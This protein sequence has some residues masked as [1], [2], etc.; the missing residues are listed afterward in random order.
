[1][2]GKPS[3]LF[4]TPECP[5][6]PAGGGALRTAALLEYVA[7]RYDVD[8]AAFRQPGDP[9]PRMT[10][11]GRLARE[12]YVVELPFHSRN[13]AA[14][15]V[16]NAMRA[17]R[18]VPP[19]NDRFA[20]FAGEMASC[21][22]GR[23]YNLAIMEHFWCAD[24][25][26]LISRRAGRTI[27]DL[28]NIESVLHMRCAASEPPPKA[29]LHRRF[30]RACRRLEQRRLPEFSLVL[31]TSEADAA[32][33]RGI[34]PDA[35]AAVYP[36]TIPSV[37]APRREETESIVFSANMEY[38]PNLAAV[39]F[40]RREIWPRLRAEWPGLTWVLAGKN[41]EAVRQEAAG[42]ARIKVTGPVEDAIAVLAT[43]KVAVAPMLAGSGTRVKILEAWA[44]GTPVVS[45]SIGAE[46]LP[47]SD[48]EHLLL[49]NDPCSFAAAVS[50]LLADDECRRRIGDAGRRLYSRGFTWEAGWLTLTNLGI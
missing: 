23:R 4:L 32:I 2:A 40:F 5:Y 48:G 33:V 16:R 3:A 14:R 30:G 38:H 10:R 47:A 9:D 46:G 15:A 26:P 31:V 6:P 41:A 49:A 34:A 44:A 21:F 50:R 13:G 27:L 12:I 7:P 36:N 1:M 39:R 17:I 18:G 43:A 29:A 24:Y 19:L 42:D 45:T 20:G 11:L 37:P 28:H 22:P 35:N 8:V 25:G